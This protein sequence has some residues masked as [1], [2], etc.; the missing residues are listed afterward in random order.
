MVQ[1]LCRHDRLE[2]IERERSIQLRSVK[3]VAQF[4]VQPY[5]DTPYS[6]LIPNDFESFVKDYETH[7]GRL[8]LK[9]MDAY[10][11]VDFISE[12][13]E[14]VSRYIILTTNEEELS[15]DLM[16]QD[17]HLIREHVYVYRV[18]G[19]RIAYEVRLVDIV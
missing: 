8:N 15:Q 14:G 13:T 6:R 19:E 4:K 9:R 17:Y 18:E 5:E 3:K 16:E 7:Q 11:L 2:E 10:G 12:D 1:R